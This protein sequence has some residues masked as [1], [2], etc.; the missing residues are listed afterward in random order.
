MSNVKKVLIGA[1]HMLKL[2][3]FGHIDKQ[4]S[5]RANLLSLTDS[6]ILAQVQDLKTSC[7]V[8]K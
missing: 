3:E 1:N 4:F 8:S 5:T 6:A 2:V 7:S